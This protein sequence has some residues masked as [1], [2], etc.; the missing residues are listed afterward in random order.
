M[1][2]MKNIEEAI[3]A[4][5]ALLSEEEEEEMFAGE[6]SADK[7]LTEPRNLIQTDNNLSPSKRNLMPKIGDAAQRMGALQCSKADCFFSVAFCVWVVL[8]LAVCLPISGLKVSLFPFV[9]DDIILMFFLGSA[10]VASVFSLSMGIEKLRRR[11]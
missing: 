5:E 3:E 1:D 2:S 4:A 8:L 10:A 6:K 9:N 7:P 11:E